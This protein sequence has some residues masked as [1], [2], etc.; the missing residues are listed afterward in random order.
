MAKK[1]FAWSYSSLNQFETCPFRYRETRITKTI[2]EPQSEAMLWGNKLHKELEM[3]VKDNV[4]LSKACQPFEPIV[5]ALKDKATNS[6]GVID[7]EQ[8]MCLNTDL[9]ETKYF[10][11][12]AWVRGIVDVTIESNSKVFIGDYKTGKRKPDSEQLMLSA[13]MVMQARP[14]VTEVT[15]SFLW[16][17]TNQVDKEVF[18]RDDLARIWGTFVPRATR[19]EAAIEEDKMPKRESGLCKNWCPVHHCEF[20]GKFKEKKDV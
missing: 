10:G 14:W 2:S 15:N 20:N 11:S 16:L 18:D 19:M 12:D 9:Q 5:K 8:K 1:K 4:P 6:G 3:Y 17:K 13:G 7:A